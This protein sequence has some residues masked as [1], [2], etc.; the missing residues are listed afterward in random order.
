VSGEK[1][2]QKCNLTIFH[3]V[4]SIMQT[5][6]FWVVAIGMVAL[7]ASCHR[8]DRVT[9]NDRDDD[10]DLA[11]T[12][13]IRINDSETTIEGISDGGFL[14]Y[15]HNGDRLLAGPDGKGGVGMDLYAYGKK[16][17]AG[18][19]EGRNLVA[20]AVKELIWL[21]IDADARM[22]RIY[23]KGGYPALLAETDS[24]KGDYVKGLYF[25]RLLN[26]DTLS[27]GEMA[28][29]LKKIGLTVSSDHGREQLL[30]RVDTS[31]LK[32]DSVA[33]SYLEVAAGIDGDFEKSQALTYFLRFPLPERR[34]VPTL[35][36]A[37]TVDGDFERS[38]VLG[39]LID[40]GVVEGAS[41]DTL[42]AVIGDMGGDFE[43]G[44]LLKEI[45]RADVKET[46]SWAGLIRASSQL[47]G[48]N[49]K[50]NV[51]IEIAHRLPRTDSL[52]AVYTAAARTVHSDNDY[53]RVMRAMEN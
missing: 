16:I 8:R 32:N 39:R 20:R 10:L 23:R 37:K 35:E 3:A 50:G 30:T 13:D 29:V 36:A 14:D 6:R 5:L 15:R 2:R 26:I 47:D 21:G 38:N 41:F 34:Y 44:K 12:G 27:P 7:A 52:R 22:D 40:K 49:E 28:A 53:G 51:L 42:L 9:I 17:D 25:S 45:S 31:Y 46:R 18:S 11:Y 4:L 1:S 19:V 43:K 24:M 48:D 33:G